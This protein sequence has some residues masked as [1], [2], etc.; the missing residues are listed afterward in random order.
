MAETAAL[1]LRKYAEEFQERNPHLRLFNAV[2]HLDEATPH[3]HLDFVPFATGQRR[4]LSTRVS[5][6]KALEQQG[7][8][9]K[10]KFETCSKLWIDNEKKRLSELMLEHGIEW[11]QLGTERE[12]LSVLDYKKQERTKEIAALDKEISKAADKAVKL[13]AVDNIA[14]KKSLIGDKIT[15]SREDYENLTDLAKKQIAAEKKEKKLKSENAALQNKISEQ[16]AVINT[17]KSEISDS[18]SVSLRIENQK[19]KERVSA[20]EKFKSSVESFLDRCGMLE[21]FMNFF[22]SAERQ[23]QMQKSRKQEME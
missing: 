17:L 22:R 16:N 19:L 12:H 23:T 2:I 5:L 18:K 6:S 3:L 8:S 10:G 14:A 20:L 7:F 15:V 11:E 1:I 21:K 9:S 13:N 4:G